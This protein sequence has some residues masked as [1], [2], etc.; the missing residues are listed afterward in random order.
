MFAVGLPAFAWECIDSGVSPEVD[1]RDSDQ[2]RNR[3]E[4]GPLGLKSEQVCHL[5]A[6]F[7]RFREHEC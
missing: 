3:Q 1:K 7:H 6:M 4:G 5:R 2:I